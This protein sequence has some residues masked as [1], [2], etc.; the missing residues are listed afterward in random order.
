MA[1]KISSTEATLTKAWQNRGWLACA[2]WPLSLLFGLLS[3]IRRSLYFH[4]WRTSTRLPVPIIVVGN[5]FV[6]GTG[7]TPLTIWLVQALR[8]AGYRPGVIS[9]GYGV[10]PHLGTRLVAAD[11]AA[12]EVGDE[13]LLIAL[14]TQCP[15]VVGRDR[16]AAGKALLASHPEVNLILSDDGLQHYRLQRQIEIVLFDSRGNGNGW[17]LPAGPLREPTTRG[18]DFTVVNLDP[19]AA[20]PR[21][22]PP[23]A[24]RM[25]LVGNVAE[26]LGDRLQSVPLTGFQTTLPAPRIV[27]A[28]GIGNPQRFFNMLS[29]MGLVFQSLSLPD[30]Y[31]FSMNPF[32]ALNAEIILITEKDAVKC[33]QIKIIKNDPRIW[34]VPVTANID[35]ALAQQI[36][37]KLRGH[38]TA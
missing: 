9:R 2:L 7:K 16:V 21:S 28:A 4:G 18:R 13:P 24:M 17:L 30:H 20:L 37:E 3:A 34:V 12:A 36:V 19:T 25:E 32:A 11:S 22:M 14:R 23:S 33:S 26:R 27:A 6:G 8:L 35:V 5:I 31:D 15:V 1:R 38:P 29:G 10:N